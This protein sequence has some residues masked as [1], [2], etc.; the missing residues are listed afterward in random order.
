MSIPQSYSNYQERY[1]FNGSGSTYSFRPWLEITWVP[2]PG[3]VQPQDQPSVPKARV[4][5]RHERRH[6]PLDSSVVVSIIDSN[7][8][9]LILN[10]VAWMPGIDFKRE[11]SM[12]IQI[13]F[14]GAK[15]LAVFRGRSRCG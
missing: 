5:D 1:L 14:S 2:E 7:P 13:Y 6:E 12:G 9:W 11:L 3:M 10:A 15:T 4:G 8:S